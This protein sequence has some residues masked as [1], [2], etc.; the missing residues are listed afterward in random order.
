M[1]YGT[2]IPDFSPKLNLDAPPT[3][4][5]APLT[6][7]PNAL[8][9]CGFCDKLQKQ[10]KTAHTHAFTVLEARNLKSVPLV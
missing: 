9:S 4:L 5:E 6:V 3:P 7:V 10:I 1:R 2:R 8:V